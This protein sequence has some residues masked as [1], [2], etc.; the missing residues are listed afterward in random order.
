LASVKQGGR[1]SFENEPRGKKKG[2]GGGERRHRTTISTSI[3]R[4]RSKEGIKTLC[5]GWVVPR[6][7]RTPKKGGAGVEGPYS[8]FSQT[9][10]RD[11]KREI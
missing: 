2:K 11:Q 6:S 8:P 10:N 5:K 9:K 3:F 4:S 1:S 7:K